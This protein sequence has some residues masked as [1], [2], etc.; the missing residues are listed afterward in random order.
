MD[1]LRHRVLLIR[2]GETVF[3]REE[4]LQGTHD[5]PLTERGRLQ[6]ELLGRRLTSS[7]L[8]PSTWYVSPLGRVRETSALLRQAWERPLVPETVDARLREISCGDYDG[9]LRAELDGALLQRI[10]DDPGQRYPGGESLEDVI[11]RARDFLEGT[12]A[13]EPF[14]RS[15][16]AVSPQTVVIVS[17]GNFGRAF[18][19]AA[20]RLGSDF[21]QRATLDNTGLCVFDWSVHSGRLIRWNDTAHLPP[22]LI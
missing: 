5:S 2:H 1:P 7:G 22:E 15:A 21:A 20:L 11:E 19:S 10:A 3:N 4:R 9:R 6:A 14:G 18:G 12:Q 17:H 16:T 13:G 8:N